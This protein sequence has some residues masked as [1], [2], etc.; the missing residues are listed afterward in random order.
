LMVDLETIIRRQIM[1]EIIT[2]SKYVKYVLIKP[3]VR[4]II[5]KHSSNI[6]YNVRPYEL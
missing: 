6:V 1:A 2:T 3:S 5:R 4:L